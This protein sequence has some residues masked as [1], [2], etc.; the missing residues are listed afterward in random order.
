MG[1]NP[2]TEAFPSQRGKGGFGST[3]RCGPAQPAPPDDPA[4]VSDLGQTFESHPFPTIQAGYERDP[5]ALKT[6][7]QEYKKFASAK[8]NK[9]V[10]TLDK[11]TQKN[12]KDPRA[13]NDNLIKILGNK[14]FLYSCYEKIKSNRGA[15][16]PGTDHQTVDEIAE[17]K[18]E[19]M[20]KE[21]LAGNFTF[22]KARRIYVEK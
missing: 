19:N 9:V 12:R 18:F 17:I 13:Q 15:L 2:P 20:S 8:M 6:L 14:Y 10:K 16:T 4:Q 5:V 1:T 7:R 22:G 3:G 11:I 21:I